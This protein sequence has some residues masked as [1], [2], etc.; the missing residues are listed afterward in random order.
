MTLKRAFIL[1]VLGLFVYL[2]LYTWN[3]RTGCLDTLAENT[4]LEVIGIILS[5]VDWLAT[6][7]SDTWNRYVDLVNVREERDVL[8][9]RL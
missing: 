9:E 1:L 7:V 5:P 3:E 4:G 8:A 2:G 6:G